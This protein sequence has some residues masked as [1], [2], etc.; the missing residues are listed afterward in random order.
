MVGSTASE[1]YSNNLTLAYMYLV[2]ISP[3][4]GVLSDTFHTELFSHM[5]AMSIC[6]VHSMDFW[7]GWRKCLRA[8]G[9]YFGMEMLTY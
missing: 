3:I 5:L 2:K 1:Q 4:G 6:G 8:L 9:M 7:A